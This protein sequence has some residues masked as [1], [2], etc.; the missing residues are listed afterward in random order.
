V[1]H[2][3][4][5][6]VYVSFDSTPDGIVLEIRDNGR[7]FDP[8]ADY[9]G[10]IGLQTMRERAVRLGGSLEVESTRGKGSCLRVWVPQSEPVVQATNG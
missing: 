5:T 2:A 1:K 4:A 10:H 3:H 8:G 9:P 6:E 7:G